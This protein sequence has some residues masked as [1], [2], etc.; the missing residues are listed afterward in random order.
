[1]GRKKKYETPA[2][3][4]SAD[5]LRR[6]LKRA[7]DKDAKLEPPISEWITGILINL[8]DDVTLKIHRKLNN[9]KQKAVKRAN[10]SQNGNDK[11][12][13]QKFEK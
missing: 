5:S 3:K 1:M 13:R 2:L 6:R 12:K 7:A 11:P 9:S 4:K 8:A 10:K